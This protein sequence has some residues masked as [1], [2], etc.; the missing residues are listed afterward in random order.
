MGTLILNA[1]ADRNYPVVQ[2]SVLVVTILFVAVNLLADVVY[3]ALDRRI[4]LGKEW[5]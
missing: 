2:A 3:T 4:Q 1:I 5:G